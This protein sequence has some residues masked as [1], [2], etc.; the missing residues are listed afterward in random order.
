MLI[1]G[2]LAL[3]GSAN[4]DERSLF[5]NYEMMIAF[6]APAD[7]RQFSDWIEQQRQRAQAWQPRAPSL[8]R[9]FVEGLVRW[10]AF[11]I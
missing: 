1:D 3:V 11:Q 4:L 10:L 9:E 5:L 6:F 2:E 8:P 7:V